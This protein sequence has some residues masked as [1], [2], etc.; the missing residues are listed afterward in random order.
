MNNSK[1]LT[2]ILMCVFAL[3]FA[4][5]LPLNN[6]A[7]AQSNAAANKASPLYQSEEEFLRDLGVWGNIAKAECGCTIDNGPGNYYMEN[8]ECKQ[9]KCLRG[10]LYKKNGNDGYW[11]QYTVEKS[12][13]KSDPTPTPVDPQLAST[14]YPKK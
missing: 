13:C 10:C 14:N 11:K 1:K 7:R 9:W 8:G 3:V 5:G 12:L 2:I 6:L 4:L